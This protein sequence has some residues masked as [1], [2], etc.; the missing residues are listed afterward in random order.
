MASTIS[1]RAWTTPRQ[2]LAFRLSKQPAAASFTLWSLAALLFLAACRAPEEPH[3]DLTVT[4]DWEQLIVV[5]WNGA[6]NPTSPAT[7]A[8][9]RVTLGEIPAGDTRTFVAALPDSLARYVVHARYNDNQFEFM[10]LCFTRQSLADSGWRVTIP[11][12]LSTC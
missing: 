1:N 3:H 2:P 8:Q 9:Q 10:T 11:G 4:N 12:S 5:Q 7:Q 6:A